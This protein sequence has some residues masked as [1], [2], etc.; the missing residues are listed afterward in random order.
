MKANNLAM[1]TETRNFAENFTLIMK[2]KSDILIILALL[3]AMVSCGE[4]DSKAKAER[5][6]AALKER[7]DEAAAFKVAVTPTIDCLP[8]YLLKDSMLYDTA[9]VDIRLKPFSSH[10]DI[11][12]ALVGGSVQAAA[13]ELVR[14]M[15][16]R[17]RHKVLLRA[18]AVT[19]LQWVLVGNK[20]NNITSLK[21]LANHMIAMTRFSATDWLTSQIKKD[22][23]TDSIVFSVQ[24][25]DIQLRAKMLANNEMDAAWLPQPYAT[26]AI[27]RGNI[28]L[29]DSENEGR[30]F[31]LVVF[32]ETGAKDADAREE[33]L[34]E[35][36]RAWNRAVELIN[37]RGLRYY[38]A[39]IK[40][41][42]G[43]DEKTIAQLP[44][45]K[46][47]PCE[48]PSRADVIAAEKIHFVK[49]TPKVQIR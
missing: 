18:V 36:K 20:K 2:I 17:K 16:L 26:A 7:A 47:K 5:H 4:S 46:F 43:A 25:N 14:I 38:S 22:A 37:K 29:T 24:I 34:E 27:S 10:M 21:R 35:F 13:T 28:K 32:R 1:S 9:K 39:L 45:I 44:K 8:L 23:G 11:D 40:K 19:P 6:A 30:S 31:G 49:H 42:M 3:L 15:D 12:T 33:Q 41:Y 48:G